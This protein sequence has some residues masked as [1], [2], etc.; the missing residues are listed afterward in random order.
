MS[1]WAT[2]KSKV[3]FV[4]VCSSP[5]AFTVQVRIKWK[6]W[7][8]GIIQGRGRGCVAVPE[9]AFLK[10]CTHFPFTGLGDFFPLTSHVAPTTLFVTTIGQSDIWRERRTR[11]Y[12]I[13][14]EAKHIYEL[15][16][17][18]ELFAMRSKSTRRQRERKR[19]WSGEFF[20]TD[21]GS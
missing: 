1:L 17:S 13:Q 12:C 18:W 11:S 9:V 7:D 15:I 5:V 14:G 16:R 2:G 10:W 19:T 21:D 6:D 4:Q 3:S 20:H 8:S